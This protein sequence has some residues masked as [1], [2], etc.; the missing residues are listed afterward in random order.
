M[1]T[2]SAPADT[3]MMGIVH[4]AL[5]RDLERTRTVLTS[6]PLP[7]PRQGSAVGRHVVWLMEFLHTHHTGEDE[8]LWPQVRERD[9]ATGPLLDSLDTDHRRITPA[10]VTVTDAARRYAE[11]ASDEARIRLL[12]AL[13]SLTAVLVPHLEREVAEA[14]PVVSA[15]LTQAEW[16]AW[17]QEYNVRSKSLTQLGMEGHW[18]LDGIDPAGHRIVVRLVP[19]VPRFVLLYGFARAYRRRRA[20]WWPAQDRARNGTA[21]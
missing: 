17:D 19:P 16:H 18:L 15:T 9:P 12:A 13:D 20:E 14:M 6:E 5:R 4:G 2:G 21:R 7:Q 3:R 8:G 10:A 1:G 11:T